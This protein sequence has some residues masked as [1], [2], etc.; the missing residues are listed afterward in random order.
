MVGAISNATQAQPVAQSTATS[1][2]K[3]VQAKPQPAAK[4]DSVQLS[5]T[6]QAMLAAMQEATET[7]VQTAKEASNGDLQAQ[8]L[9]AKEAAARPVAAKPVAAKPVAK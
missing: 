6:A 5:A 3:P 7:P 8:K 2:H 4:T 1:A 9:L